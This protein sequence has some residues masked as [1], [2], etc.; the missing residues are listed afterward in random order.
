M[1]SP[2]ESVIQRSASRGGAKIVRREAAKITRRHWSQHKSLLLPLITPFAGFASAG[3]EISILFPMEYAKTQLQ[4]N[5]QNKDFRVFRHMRSRG[6]AVYQGLPPMLI[7]APLQG[8]LR[9]TCLEY[10]NNM[11]RD[12][13]TGKNSVWSGLLAGMASG[14][15]ESVLVVTP[16][17]TVKT[18]LI[19]SNKG[20]MEGVRYVINK[21]GVAGLYKGVVPTIIKSAS[22]QGLRFIIFNQYK[23]SIIAKPTDKLTALQSLIGGMTAGVLGAMINTPIDTIK[24][25]MQSLEASRYAGTFDCGKQMVLKEGVTSLWKGL[26]L[27][28]GRVVPGQG[29]IFMS[30]DQ[31]SNRLR[32]Q[33]E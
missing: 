33:I 29:I 8:L 5:R 12:P 17:E 15:L 22:N 14:V 18:R 2:I 10:F 9:F 1:A 28:C 19:D 30:F 31:I 32:A 25:R 13:V 16:M 7:G 27:R 4:L 6:L 23:N 20:M 21:N 3:I 11:L 24:S 26:V